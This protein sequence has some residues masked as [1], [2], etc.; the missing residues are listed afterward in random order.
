MNFQQERLDEDRS[1]LSDII[2]TEREE[3][4]FS[5][6]ITTIN[7]EIKLNQANSDRNYDEFGTPF[8]K[9]RTNS[10]IVEADDRSNI[11]SSPTAPKSVKRSP[12]RFVLMKRQRFAYTEIN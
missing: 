11:G 8:N 7:E 2:V 10:L 12:L 1:N 5:T 4:I 9:R 6:T 3:T